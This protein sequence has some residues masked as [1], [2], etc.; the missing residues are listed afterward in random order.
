[1][2]VEPCKATQ[3]KRAPISWRAE[4]AR[5]RHSGRRASWLF[6]ALRNRVSVHGRRTSTAISANP[7]T[8]SSWRMPRRSAPPVN[9]KALRGGSYAGGPLERAA[10][11][12]AGAFFA[13]RPYAWATVC[14]LP[15]GPRR[16]FQTLWG[17][18]NDAPV[19]RSTGVSSST[20]G[21]PKVARRRRYGQP[22]DPHGGRASTHSHRPQALGQH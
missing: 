6:Q 7:Y 21:K 9:G 11:S 13:S 16:E 14:S 10:S 20:S 8:P 22:G 17:L 18:L 19:R 1:M 15:H 3:R 5:T 12:A 2:K 4:C